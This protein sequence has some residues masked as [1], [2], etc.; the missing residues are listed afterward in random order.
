[1]TAPLL[2]QEWID[3]NISVIHI[4]LVIYISMLVVWGGALMYAL[5]VIEK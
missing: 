5:C 4:D 1:M 2:K 3:V